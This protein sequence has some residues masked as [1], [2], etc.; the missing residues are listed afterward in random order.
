MSFVLRDSKGLRMR[1]FL[2]GVAVWGGC[3]QWAV[4][5]VPV[6]NA[7]PEEKAPLTSR[8]PLS[9]RTYYRNLK[10]PIY[11]NS[12]QAAPDII[13]S[14]RKIYDRVCRN[15]HGESGD[16]TGHSGAM[17]PVKP[18]DFTNCLFQKRRTDG[19]LYYVVKFGSWPM[20][21]MVPLITEDEVWAVIAYIRTF[22]K[23]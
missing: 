22:C 9:Q 13:E 19:E 7:I 15:C 21:P 4:M 3:I 6:A 12:Q 2:A 16:G 14:G 1:W 20:P 11:E 5:T 10:S 8:I 23:N 17:L 18:R